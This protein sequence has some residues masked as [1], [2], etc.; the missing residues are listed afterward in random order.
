MSITE[1]PTAKPLSPDPASP[2]ESGNQLVVA[3][4]IVAGVVTLGLAMI[5]A[6]LVN[7]AVGEAI[8]LGTALGTII[9]GLV[10]ALNPPTG[11]GKVLSAAKQVPQ[12]PQIKEP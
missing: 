9:G 2:P 6:A 7:P 8:G 10:N 11:I 4:A 3:L 1:T 12:T 5:G